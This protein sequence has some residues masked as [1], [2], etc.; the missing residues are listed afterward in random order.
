MKKYL[1]IAI[2]LMMAL[3]TGCNKNNDATVG[4]KAEEKEDAVISTEAMQLVSATG[5]SATV[6]VENT[7]DAVWQS[8]NWRDYHLE[9]MKDGE[10]YKVEQIGDFAN[11]MELMIFTPGQKATHTFEFEKRYGNLPEGKYRI[12]KYW[13]AKA[14]ENKEAGE[15]VTTCE[16]SI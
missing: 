1:I 4:D 15:L 13:W 7:S 6:K 3:V 8:G 12:V 16:F 2:C 9:V 5:K 11:T 10:W 14:T